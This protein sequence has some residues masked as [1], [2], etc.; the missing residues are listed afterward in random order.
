MVVEWRK[1]LRARYGE[2]ER[3]HDNWGGFDYLHEE[4]ERYLKEHPELKA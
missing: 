4:L 3:K 2:R 1:Y